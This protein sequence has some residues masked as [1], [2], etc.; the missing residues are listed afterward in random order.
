MSTDNM[1][2]TD[3]VLAITKRLRLDASASY[4]TIFDTLERKL[5]DRDDILARLEA[6]HIE[7]ADLSAELDE[8]RQTAAP[9]ALASVTKAAA[10]AALALVAELEHQNRGRR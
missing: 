1:S 2:Q 5:A 6:A 3:L 10:T 9:S 7:S 8:L 4:R